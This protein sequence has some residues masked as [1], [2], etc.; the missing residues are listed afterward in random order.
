MVEAFDLSSRDN[1]SA[2]DPYLKIICNGQTMSDRENYQ[3]DCPDPKFYKKFDFEGVF[4]G[5]SPV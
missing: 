5:T 1:G 4:P 2:S 3:L